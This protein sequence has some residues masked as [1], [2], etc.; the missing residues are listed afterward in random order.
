MLT[1]IWILGFIHAP[2]FEAMKTTFY[3][4]K[5][6]KRKHKQVQTSTNVKKEQQRCL[7]SSVFMS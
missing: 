5:D 1:Q 4:K 3:Q 7:K 6:N 2:L